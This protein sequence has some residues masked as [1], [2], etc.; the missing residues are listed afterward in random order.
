MIQVPGSSSW[1]RGGGGRK[2]GYIVGF[3]GEGLILPFTTPQG[4]RKKIYHA[5]TSSNR[6]I[7]LS[8]CVE[9]TDQREASGV[10]YSTVYTLRTI[11]MASKVYI[12]LPGNDRSNWRVLVRGA[13]GRRLLHSFHP[14]ET[15][16]NMIL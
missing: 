11:I 12:L 15:R 5:N 2:G 3:M 8:G 6:N 14:V 4:D 16:K 10:Q 7:S 13:A 9:I 1:P